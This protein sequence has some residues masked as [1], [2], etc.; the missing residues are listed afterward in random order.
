[1]LI[2]IGLEWFH[3]SCVDIPMLES[4]LLGHSSIRAGGGGVSP[5]VW[6]GMQRAL[7]VS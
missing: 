5:R 1:M 7:V 6:I 2:L 3:L 4:D